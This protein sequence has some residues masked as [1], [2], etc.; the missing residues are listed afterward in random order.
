MKTGSQLILLSFLIFF[1]S[2]SSE[3][4]QSEKDKASYQ[5]TR[6]LL[7][8]KERKDPSMFLSVKGNSHKNLV[9][10][11]VIKGRIT[12]KSSIA[13]YKD[14]EIKFDFFSGTKAL[15]E[16]DKETI[17]VEVNPGQS[18]NFKSKYFAPK[19]TDSVALVVL[20]AKPIE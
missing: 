11:T 12:S 20:G 13:S 17:F 19:G 2:C 5:E 10:Q 6:D 3:S 9:G 14:V 8:R 1:A 16:S 4:S 7:L 15:L 18:V